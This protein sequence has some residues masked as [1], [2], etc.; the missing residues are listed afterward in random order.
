MKKVNLYKT[1]AL[2]YFFCSL[3]MQIMGLEVISLAMESEPLLPHAIWYMAI[4][5]AIFLKKEI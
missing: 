5:V 4:D 2:P 1:N 3:R